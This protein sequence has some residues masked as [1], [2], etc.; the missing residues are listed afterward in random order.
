MGADYLFWAAFAKWLTGGNAPDEAIYMEVATTIRVSHCRAREYVMRF[1]PGALP[2]VEAFWSISMCD[3]RDGAF[4]ANPIDRHTIGDQTRG[5]VTNEMARWR[6]SITVA[7]RW[8]WRSG[9]TG[10]P[11]GGSVLHGPPSL[12]S[13]RQPTA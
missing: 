7:P 1:V 9:L 12:R 2:P 4:V 10:C 13:R 8:A 3:E 11:P 5:L 6:S